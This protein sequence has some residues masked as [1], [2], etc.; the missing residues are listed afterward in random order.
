MNLAEP[1]SRTTV[2]KKSTMDAR[3]RSGSWGD[4]CDYAQCDTNH[5]RVDSDKHNFIIRNSYM[6]R[7]VMKRKAFCMQQ[8][9]LAS[10]VLSSKPLSS[11][12]LRRSFK[13]DPNHPSQMFNALNYCISSSIIIL[14]GT[15]RSLLIL[16]TVKIFCINFCKL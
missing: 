15:T 10:F 3:C 11:R 13:S 6:F 5:S 4:E 8:S 1:N 2:E 16:I 14:T 9:S 7:N 12:S